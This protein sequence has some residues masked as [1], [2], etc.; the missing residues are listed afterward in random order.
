MSVMSGDYPT[1]G[2]EVLDA[3]ATRAADADI[4]AQLAS[5]PARPRRGRPP[6]S[7]NKP[8]T[9]EHGNF[10]PPGQRKSPPKEPPTADDEA[11]AKAK[12]AEKKQLAKTYENKILEAN[13]QIFGFLI[14]AGVP[15]AMFY[16]NGVAPNQ[17][18]TGGNPNW[19]DVANQVAIPP[20]LAKVAGLTAAELQSST[21]GSG[22]TTVLEGDSPIRLLVLIGATVVM[23][24]PY[25]RNLNEIRK[26]MIAMQE[27]ANQYNQQQ[28]RAAAATQGS[29]IVG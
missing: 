7:K 27:A 13:E 20:H 25:L 18:A 2:P 19:T 9:D 16:K 6:G 4:L 12:V 14:Q 8:K 1:Q 22:I 21:I 11:K 5:A 24:V 15:A 3:E 26:R 23:G 10:I 17:G 28:A 29:G